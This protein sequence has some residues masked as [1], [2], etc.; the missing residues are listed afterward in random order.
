MQAMILQVC[1]LLTFRGRSNSNVK[2]GV[3]EAMLSKLKAVGLDKKERVGH[4]DLKRA[5]I[6]VPLFFRSGRATVLLTQRPRRMKSHGG[7]VC[8]PGGKQDE[9]DGGDDLKTAL[10]EAEE[11]VGLK[12]QHLRPLARLQSVESKN[13]LAVTP[14]VALFDPPE[15]AEPNQLKIN[16]EEVEDA[17][18]VPLSWFLDDGNLDS[19]MPMEWRGDE[20]LLRTYLWDDPESQKQFKIW[21]L[22]AHIVHSVAEIV[23]S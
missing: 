18:S 15:M 17:F 19:I 6:L 16:A 7:E 5:S 9:E 22:T 12:P 14:F 2:M 11:E 13:N 10:R 23:C 4:G 1:I 3:Q 8:C 20:F 21:G